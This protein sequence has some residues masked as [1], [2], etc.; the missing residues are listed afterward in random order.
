MPISSTDGHGLYINA[1]KTYEE[2]SVTN[3]AKET[4]RIINKSGMHGEDI[5]F[6]KE[7][8]LLLFATLALRGL[9]QHGDGVCGKREIFLRNTNQR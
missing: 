1:C 4:R 8:T 9:S 6:I 2:I 5:D 7:Y 3:T